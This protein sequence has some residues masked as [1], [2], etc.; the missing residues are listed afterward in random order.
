VLLASSVV[1]T[2]TWA[3]LAQQQSNERVLFLTPV[4]GTPSDSAFAKE[5]GSAIRSRMESRLRHK[6][7]VVKDELIDELLVTSG[8]QPGRIIEPAMAPQVARALQADAYVVGRVD[9]DGPTPMGE[10]RLVD[11]RRSGLSGWMK[12]QGQ[13]GDPPRAFADRV[14]DSLSNQIKAAEHARDCS[15]RRDRGDFRRARERADRAFELYANHPSA[16][17][18]VSYVFEA[19]RQPAESLIWVLE[20]A[21]VGDPE[22]LRAW[23][24]LARQYMQKGDTAQAVDAFSRQLQANP[25]DADIRLTVA[26]GY[27]A[28]KDYAEARDVLNEGLER[29]ASNLRFVQLKS[30]ACFDGELWE[31]A[32]E[33]MAQQYELDSALVGDSEFYP[34]IFGVAQTVGDTAAML[35]WSGEAVRRLPESIL[36]WKARASAL[37]DA[38]FADSAVAAYERLVE[39][40]GN[41]LI[42]VLAAASILVDEVKID[43]MT[44]LDTAKLFRAGRLLDR[45]TSST[46][47][48]TLV[49]N[50]A[51]LYFRPGRQLVQSRRD[52]VDELAVGVD[53]LDKSLQYD[54]MNRLTNQA[55]FFLGLGIFFLAADM[56]S[57]IVESKSCEE[58]E[59]YSALLNRGIQAM[60]VGA[61][62]SQQT[63]DQILN[64][65]KR[66]EGR[67]PTFRRAFKCS[68]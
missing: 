17:I 6:L 48:T 13:P 26:S 47:D 16:A 3:Q 18:C 50:S 37:K 10:F 9:R 27:I 38:G 55:N 53:W 42:S 25:D 36:L 11:Q 64:L 21:T 65:Y 35:E 28:I 30:R 40:D 29:D 4:P 7:R 8:F 12:V 5:V 41:D 51:L 68:G 43:T 1:P 45:L 39:L 2:T 67:P 52:H 32:L 19:T 22:L 57:K 23:E 15:A 59:E 44:A 14:V 34:R 46:T 31:C 66:Y 56:D 24:D 60:N 49:M 63:A 54:W 58:V 61:A 20:K 33:A 62:V